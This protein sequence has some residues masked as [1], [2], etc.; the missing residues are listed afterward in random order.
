VKPILM[1]SLPNS[2][3]SWLAETIAESMRL[4]YFAEYFNPLRN[5]TRERLL[6]RDFGCEL[7]GAAHNIASP[8]GLSDAEFA[9]SWGEDRFEMT[10]EVFSP[11]KLE[12]YMRHFECFVLLRNERVSFPPKRLR[13]WS[14]YEHAWHALAARGLAG[15]QLS[16]RDRALE[17]HR[18]MR[19]QLIADARR[20]SVP[21]LEYDELMSANVERVH[22]ALSSAI[23][24]IDI[25]CARAVVRTRVEK[26]V[27]A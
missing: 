11:F 6:L 19:G 3:S 22:L 5:E 13:I 10:K 14:F 20:L 2:G 17:A 7:V 15:H 12:W 26:V 24:G 9:K 18:V 23:E 27:G 16:V 4:R 25:E 8:H 21:V 1:L